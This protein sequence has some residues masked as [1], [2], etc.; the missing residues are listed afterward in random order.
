MFHRC[1]PEHFGICPSDCL[2]HRG[3]KPEFPYLGAG[4]GAWWT[5]ARV[6]YTLGYTTNDPQMRLP[7]GFTAVFSI[8]GLLF[9]TSYSAFRFA[10]PSL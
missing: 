8:L 10:Y 3:C 9:T 7:G 6:V 2:E 4:L 1:S 5:L